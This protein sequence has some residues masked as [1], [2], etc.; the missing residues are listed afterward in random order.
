MI[1]VTVNLSSRRTLWLAQEEIPSHKIFGPGTKKLVCYSLCMTKRFN[2]SNISTYWWETSLLNMCTLFSLQE[3]SRLHRKQK[4]SYQEKMKRFIV[5]NGELYYK[6]RRIR[7]DM[8]FLS[9]IIYQP[10]CVYNNCLIRF[11]FLKKNKRRFY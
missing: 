5:E 7:C 3:I 1:T 6:Q 10:I 4:A 9:L 11:I 2:T 8:T